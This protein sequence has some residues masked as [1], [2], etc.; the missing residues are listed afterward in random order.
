MIINNKK[1]GFVLVI[2]VIII[3]FIISSLVLSVSIWL[4]SHS[5][6]SLE[7]AQREQ[8]LYV[9]Q[10]GIN[11]MI[12]N[13]NSGTTYIDGQSIS[14]TTTGGNGT[15]K[16]TYY[17]SDTFGG[18]AYIKGEGTVGQFTRVV[19]ASIIGASD[20]F[21][22]CLYTADGGY[23]KTHSNVNYITFNNPDPPNGYGSNYYYNST[24]GT[25]PQPDWTWYTTAS[26]YPV[27][28]FVERDYGVN[29]TITF[30]SPTYRNKVVFINYTGTSISATLTIRLTNIPA[31]PP[32]QT[33]ITNFPK[34]K[35]TI[36]QS[37]NTTWQP[38]NYSGNIDY[39]L[40]IHIP[41][42]GTGSVYINLDY[43]STDTHIITFQG[44][45]YTKSPVT[46]EYGGKYWGF[47]D[48]R[49]EMFAGSLTTDWDYLE[50]SDLNGDFRI[51]TKTI[52]DYTKDYYSYPP[53]HFSQGASFKTGTYREEY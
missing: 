53:P 41:K 22:Y 27:N 5:Y 26:N 33:Y 51:T 16:A 4:K 11:E 2:T 7:I 46:I 48:I 35:F 29:R 36:S 40:F 20:V 28:T 10:Y 47:L 34:V 30:N 39:P 14:G 21:K 24:S 3:A 18:T 9:A 15:Y 38:V 19:F 49:G 45:F 37:G 42:V 43:R 13:M 31:S 32:P 23:T 6:E 8:T 1:K 52:F 17:T 25:L 12:Y 50:P 44:V